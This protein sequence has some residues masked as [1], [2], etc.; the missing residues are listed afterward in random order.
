MVL[1]KSQECIV[2]EGVWLQAVQGQGVKLRERTI[3]N[4]TDVSTRLNKVH[5]APNPP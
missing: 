4:K 2:N 1:A 5:C 3:Y